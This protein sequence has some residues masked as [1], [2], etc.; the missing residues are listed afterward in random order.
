MGRSAQVT[1]GGDIMNWYY[2]YLFGLVVGVLI[3]YIGGVSGKAKKP[4]LWSIVFGVF[5][6][7]TLP[8]LLWLVFKETSKK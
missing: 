4:E 2:V 3:F 7:V 6:P 1:L 5:W 8:F